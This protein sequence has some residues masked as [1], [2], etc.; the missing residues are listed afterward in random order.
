LK[1]DVNLQQFWIEPEEVDVVL[2]VLADKLNPVS[3][4]FRWRPQLSDPN[5]EMVLECAINAQARAIVTFNV[6]DFLP[7]TLKFGINVV[8]PGQLVR[9]LNLASRVNL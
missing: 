7:A 5:D 6:K 9:S 2:S 8:Q 3:I 1:R 4:Y